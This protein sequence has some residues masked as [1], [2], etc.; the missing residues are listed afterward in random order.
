MSASSIEHGGP[1]PVRLL[2]LSAP[3][4]LVG[5]LSGLVLWALD[6]VAHGVQDTLWTTLPNAWGIDPSSPWWI[7][8]MLTVIGV[9]VGL[10]L[11]F[12]PGRGGR[13][14]ATVELIAPPQPIAAV[15]S[16]L[17]AVVLTLVGGVSLGPESPIIAIN[18]A[19]AVWGL[20]RLWKGF[21]TELA[22]ILTAA[23]TIGALFGTPVAAAL[24]FTGT[25]AARPGGGSL[26]DKL[27]LPL[28]SASTGS[29]VTYLL[30]GGMGAMTGITPYPGVEAWDLLWG[31]LVAAG[32]ALLGLVAVFLLPPVH[33]L[34]HGL[35]WPILAT[36]IGGLVLGILGAIGGPVT[37]FKGLEQGE[38]LVQAAPGMTLG[39]LVI[40]LVVKL[41][42]LVVSAGSGF[43]GG[44][45][46]PS[47]FLGIAAGLVAHALFPGIPEALAL[48]AGVLGFTLAVARDGWIA[49][50]VAVAITGDIHLLPIL[51]V[52][53]L[54]AWLLVAR[55][56]EM[57]AP[58]T[59]A[60][61]GPRL[62]EVPASR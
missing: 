10:V 59:E 40:V 7:I 51:C 23:G 12:V 4:A 48:A 16:I 6:T 17:L 56:P 29:I 57:L 53:L 37:L 38:Q 32:A 34:M 54:P 9:L 61:G 27:F 5:L 36:T 13:D 62:A 49:L 35:R 28:V 43:R 15:P 18:T 20:T 25:V 58:E 2:V 19:L 47:V 31:M 30:G 1:T 26:W 21:P 33:R 24:V 14:S 39:A 45:V 22:L 44:R 55:A 8:G 42:A 46:F 50:F 60:I 3:A 52:A 11:Q 41:A